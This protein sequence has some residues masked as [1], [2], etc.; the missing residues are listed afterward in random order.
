MDEILSMVFLP[1]ELFVQVERWEKASWTPYLIPYLLACVCTALVL[2]AAWQMFKCNK[3]LQG[4]GCGVILLVLFSGVHLLTF[5]EF[6]E[7]SRI[8]QPYFDKTLVFHWI[9]PGMKSAKRANLIASRKIGDFLVDAQKLTQKE[10][11]IAVGELAADYAIGIYNRRDASFYFTGL[12]RVEYTET[13]KRMAIQFADKKQVFEPEQNDEV[14]R[15]FKLVN[16]VLKA[17]W[18]GSLIVMFAVIAVV[19]A[20]VLITNKRSIEPQKAVSEI[21]GS[22]A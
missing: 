2:V 15:Y 16:F 8:A 6:R 1:Q 14:L 7:F 22:V 18:Q 12:A 21:W 17:Q 9:A 20:W 19:S 13:G 4:I 5:P 3:W 10:R 11:E